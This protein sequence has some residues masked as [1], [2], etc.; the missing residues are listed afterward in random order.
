MFLL[1]TANMVYNFREYGIE[2]ID[3][4]AHAVAKTIEHSLT[5][6]M[7]SGVIEDR[8]LFLSQLKKYSKYR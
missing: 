3:D 1:I 7:V 6:Q 5:S 2:T 4:K 8:E